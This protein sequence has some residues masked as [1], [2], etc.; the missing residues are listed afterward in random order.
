MSAIEKFHRIERFLMFIY[1]V[2]PKDFDVNNFAEKVSLWSLV[3]S[4]NSE[5][6]GFLKVLLLKKSKNEYKMQNQRIWIWPNFLPT[7]SDKTLSDKIFRHLQK[8]SSLVSDKFLSDKVQSVLFSAGVLEYARFAKKF[9]L[10]LQKLD[11]NAH[12]LRILLFK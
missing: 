10:A 9:P 12:G 1:T 6:F 4:F 2:K 11:R 3:L 5:I 7:L 8:I